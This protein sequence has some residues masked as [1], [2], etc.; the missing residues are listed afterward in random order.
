MNVLIVNYLLYNKVV[1]R[2][3]TQ[4]TTAPATKNFLINNIKGLTN[5]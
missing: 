3:Q 5:N 2:E 4:K 1:A